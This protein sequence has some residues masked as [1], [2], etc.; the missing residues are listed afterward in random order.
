MAGES[1]GFW[2]K[3]ESNYPC[4]LSRN[5]AEKS[6]GVPGLE[7]CTEDLGGEVGLPRSLVVIRTHRPAASVVGKEGPGS[8]LAA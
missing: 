6:R 1:L 7:V 5:G 4:Q 2:L 3:M 8:Y